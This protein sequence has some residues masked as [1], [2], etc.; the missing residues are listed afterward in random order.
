MHIINN[1]LTEY[2]SVAKYLNNKNIGNTKS[3][4]II[5]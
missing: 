2:K 1:D 3:V 4:K 5:Q